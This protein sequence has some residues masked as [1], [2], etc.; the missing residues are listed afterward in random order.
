MLLLLL[1]I[2]SIIFFLY[3][4]YFKFTTTTTTTTSSINDGSFPFQELAIITRGMRQSNVV[5]KEKSEFL[6]ISVDVSRR[7]APRSLNPFAAAACKTSGLKYAR[8]RLHRVYFP[9][10]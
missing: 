8:T 3:Y 1:L 2:N 4:I 7:A 10:L 9:I 5:V 6:T